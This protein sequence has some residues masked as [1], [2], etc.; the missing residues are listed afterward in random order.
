MKIP[1]LHN[2]RRGLATNSSSSHSLVF[3]AQPVASDNIESAEWTDTEFGWDHFILDSLGE[4][5][6]YG[7]TSAVS[8]YWEDGLTDE[9]LKELQTEWGHLF[10]E[11]EGKD[12]LWRSAVSGYVDHQSRKSVTAEFVA[13]L[14]DPRVIVHGGND[15]GG[16]PYGDWDGEENLPEGVTREMLG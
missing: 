2:V 16:Y 7:L 3:H 15:N 1:F 12:D 6:M 14:R 4:K 9:R 8:A 10:P 11:F 5:L 13:K